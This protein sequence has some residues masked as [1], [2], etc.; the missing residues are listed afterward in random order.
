LLCPTYDKSK[1]GFDRTTTTGRISTKS[2]FFIFLKNQQKKMGA[3]FD[4]DGSVVV[5]GRARWR[6]L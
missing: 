4:G 2:I 6:W 3:K 1:D 5:G